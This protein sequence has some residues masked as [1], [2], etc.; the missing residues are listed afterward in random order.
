MSTERRRYYRIY[1]TAL[2]KYRVVQNEMMDHERR[3]YYLNQIKVENARAALFGIE[4]QF[5]EVLEAVRRDSRP[6][7]EA[8]ELL[9]RKVN[10]LERVVSLESPEGEQTDHIEHEPCEV[11]LS[12]GG[13]AVTA[14]APLAV[15]ANLA[16]DLV[17]LP[18]HEAMRIFGAVVDC[19]ETDDDRY[20][21][22]IEFDDIREEDRDRLVN[23]VLARQSEEL[24]AARS[25]GAS[26]AA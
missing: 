17:L 14:D 4:T 3:Y 23:H 25:G 26:N 18:A 24:R 16:I 15:G 10:L 11:N 13:M 6:V 9:S 2:V 8:L 5:Q 12:A 22:A 19:R 7:A 1:D 20:A 21:I